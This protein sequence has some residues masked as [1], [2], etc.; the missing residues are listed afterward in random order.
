MDLAGTPND[1]IQVFNAVACIILGPIIQKGLYPTLTKYK[2]PFKPVAR[3]TAAFFFMSFA[4]AYA[5]GIQKLIYSRGP[6]YEYPLAC[7]ASDNGRLPNSV[8]VWVQVP[9]YFILAVGEIL[10]FVTALEYSYSKAPRDMKA[11]VQAFTQ[12]MAGIGAALGMAISPAASDPNLVKFYAALAAVMAGT[13]VVFWL[14]FHEYDRI[15]DDLDAQ[16]ATT[17]RVEDDKDT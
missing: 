14:L 7:A 5:A 4:M 16:Q 3:I 11:M 1:M 10:G 15:D 12:L 8:I 2:I 9:V 13:A 17:D 6:C